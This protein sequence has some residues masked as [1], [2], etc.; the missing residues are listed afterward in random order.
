MLLYL[1]LFFAIVSLLL[2]VHKII[3]K[4]M[5]ERKL[6]RKVQDRELTSLTSWMED[7]PRDKRD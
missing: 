5:M 6:G 7:S 2:F 3:Y 4:R 1:V